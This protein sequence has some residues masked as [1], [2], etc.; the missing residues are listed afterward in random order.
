MHWEYTT[1]YSRTPRSFIFAVV[2]NVGPGGAS[3]SLAVAYRQHHDEH[4]MASSWPRV[5]HMVTDTLA[6][7][8]VLSDPANRAPL[9]AER[10]LAQDW[11]RR[12]PGH[13]EPPPHERPSVPD[14]AQPPFVPWNR[15]REPVQQQPPLPWRDDGLSRFPFTATCVLLALLRDDRPADA[16]HPSDV[17]FQPL[18]TVFRADCAEYGLVVVDISDLDSGVKYGIVAFP[19]DYMA[20]VQSRDKCFGWDPVEDPQPEKEPD[21]ILVSPRPRVLL[22]ISQWAGKYY[23]WSDLEDHPSI[24]RLEEKPLADAAA[25]DYIWPP[26]LE[27][28]AQASSKNFTPSNKAR[29]IPRSMVGYTIVDEPPRHGSMDRAKEDRS[30][31]RAS[32]VTISEEPPQTVPV[33]IDRTIDDLLLLTQEPVSPRLEKQALAH[34]QM[35]VPFSERL[36]QRLEE[37]PNRLGPSTISSHVLRVAYTECSHLNWVSF[38]NLPPRVIAVAVTSDEL[39]G[40][41][42]LSLCVDAWVGDEEEGESDLVDP[43]VALAQSTGLQ[44]LCF[45][46]QPDRTHDE[47]SARFCSQLLQL[48]GRASEEDWEWLRPK[49]IHSTSVFLTGLRRRRLLTSSSTIRSDSSFTLGA[50]IF[51]MI[52]LFTFLG[53]LR[54]DIPDATADRHVYCARPGYSSYYSIDN[55]GLTAEVFAIRFL[56]YLRALGPYSDPDKAIL[57]VAYHGAFS[58]LASMDDDSEQHRRKHGWSPGRR[59]PPPS[60]LRSSPDPLGVRPIPAGFFDDELTPDDPSKVRLGDIPPGDWVVLVDRRDRSC[61]DSDDTTFLQYSFMRIRQPCVKFS[62]EKQSSSVEMVGGLTDFL[63]ETVPGTNVAMWER[64]VDEVEND[65]VS[66]LMRPSPSSTPSSVD[67]PTMLERVNESFGRLAE[68]SAETS[69]SSTLRESDISDGEEPV[70]EVEKEPCIDVGVMAESRAYILLDQLV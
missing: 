68:A 24:L 10:A 8:D 26:E 23:R 62:S 70:V 46:Q 56:G 12:S 47:V 19:V 67:V 30:T 52:H 22:S 25:L 2:A 29:S 21:V 28:P 44:Q 49:T 38:G 17:Q 32:S 66:A 9:E 14:T 6:L 51:P 35:L 59:P 54:K 4:N 40:A 57:R 13:H 27:A 5:H 18:S 36:R 33:D 55:T 48:W 20:E 53:P 64:R 60:P 69:A 11:Y 42:A 45:L 39:R 7:I 61:R 31:R 3:R 15:R 41:S 43:A 37:V 50:Q 58:S 63:R 1:L 16:T 34:L 65:L